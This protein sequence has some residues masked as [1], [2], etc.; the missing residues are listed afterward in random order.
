MT[1]KT[2]EKAYSIA[3]EQYAQIG[4]DTDKVLKKLAAIPISMHCWQGDDVG[5]F[6]TVG[7]E[8]SGGGI[9]ATGNY[10]GKARTIDQLRADIEKAFSLIPGRHRLN[11]HACYIDNGGKYID[12]NEMQPRH[13]QSWIDW[14]KANKLGMDFN[15]TYFSHPKAADGFTLSHPDKGIRNFWIEHGIACRKIGAAI[16]RQLGSTTVTNFW[17]PD[18]YKDVPVDR[19]SPRLRL[20]DSL[21][22]IF[23]VKVNP[24]HNLDAVESK[25][26]GIGAES[27]TVG[28]HEFYLGYAVS[29][30]KLLCLDAGHFHPT[31]MISEKISSV[32]MFCPQ[33]LLH[34]SRPVRWDSDHVV[35]LDDELQAIAKELVR[36][37]KLDKVH[38][39]LDF[40]DA[41]INRV[42]AWTIGMRNMIKALLIALLEPTETLRKIELK[43][44]Y[45]RRL[46]MLE[47]LK[48]LPWA[49][50]WDYYC[51]SRNVPVGM[52]WLDEVKKYE[53][54]VLSKR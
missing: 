10:P 30:Q 7:A 13:F 18:G 6:E 52:A 17:I 49:A 54:D 28:S 27:Y 2:I 12:R 9:Q 3:K 15:P 23:A 24:A 36:S 4:I 26:F 11:L 43:M 35:I 48:T 46:A 51:M 32:M 8:L 37:G 5:G 19:V 47:E 40:F 29:R 42:A 20:M 39:G 41:S 34:V 44:D 38:I 25:L 1:K 53:A 45:T 22:K 21:D 31:E 50:V 33:L 16:G 14:A